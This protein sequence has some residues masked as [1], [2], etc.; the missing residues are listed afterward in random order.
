METASLFASWAQN[1]LETIVFYALAV[2]AIPLAYGVIFDRA[3][4]RSGFILIGLFGSVSLLYLLLE[5]QFLAL[6]QIMIYAVGITLVV[7]I[8]LMLTNPKLEQET[9]PQITSLK[10][11]ALI[12]AVLLFIVTYLAIRSET[13]TFDVALRPLPANMVEHI[14]TGLMTAFVLP[15]EFASILLLAALM[16]SVLLAKQEPKSK[17]ASQAIDTTEEMN[18][19]SELENGRN[20]SH[21]V[22]V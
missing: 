16:G 8:A 2:F 15:F 7:V 21:A 12:S 17:T 11:P 6:A 13:A 3:V 19:Q 9:S 10:P 14:G 4:I 5:A 20:N 22:K 1:N 18:D